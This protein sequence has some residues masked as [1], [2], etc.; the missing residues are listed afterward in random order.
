MARIP[1][2]PIRIK[3]TDGH[4][5]IMEVFEP[6]T[7]ADDAPILLTMPAMGVDAR[8]YA[9]LARSAANHGLR[10]IT[11]DQRG[12]G[13]SSLR[14]E[15]G[16]DWGFVDQIDR[17]WIAAIEA[18]EQRFPAAPRVLFGHSLGGQL[19]ALFL[20]RH[21]NRVDALVTVASC[22]VWWW[23]FPWRIR[24]LVLIATQ[25]ARVVAQVLGYYPGER[26]GFAS[27]ESTGVIHDWGRQALHGRYVLGGSDRDDDAALGTISE[28]VLMM[29]L[30]GDDFFAPASAVDHLASKL[31]CTRLHITDPEIADLDKVHF[32]WVAKPEP[33]LRATASFLRERGVL[34]S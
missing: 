11:V 34:R 6:P 21:P 10:L 17:D 12:H 26:L 22:S 4:T 31:P 5:A 29:S 19:S 33:V 14:A 3:A 27:L 28:P 1:S 23:S 30:P 25:V 20:G 15:R 8:W 32:Y 18:I 9:G 16:V 7:L 13:R 2:A 24:F